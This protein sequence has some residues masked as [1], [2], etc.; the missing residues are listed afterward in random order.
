MGG[1]ISKTQK[2]NTT[3][4]IG[5]TL[6]VILAAVCL[7]GVPFVPDAYAAEKEQITLTIK[8]ILT[9]DHVSAMSDQTFLY[10]LTKKT[11]D[12]PMPSGRGLIDYYFTVSGT[13]EEQVGPITFNAAG[14][15]TYELSCVVREETGYLYDRHVYTIEVFVTNESTASVIVYNSDGTKA[16]DLRYEHGFVLFPSDPAI[17]VD[18][19]VVKTV[20][21]NPAASSTFTFR[22][23]AGDLSNPMPEGSINGVKTVQ[24]TGS[25]SAE[26]G[27]W[28]YTVEGTYFYTVSEVVSGD[29]NYTYDSS[30]YTITDTVKA[31]DSRL[32]VSRVVTNSSNRQVL[33]MMFINTYRGGGV[34]TPTPTPQPTPE[35]ETDLDLDLD[36]ESEPPDEEPNDPPMPPDHGPPPAKPGEVT[37]PGENGTYRVIGRNNAPLGEWRYEN[38]E[39]IYTEYPMADFNPDEDPDKDPVKGADKGP[40]TG[41]ESRNV[42]NIVLFCAAV[43]T[44]L[45]SA[46]YLVNGK[47]RGK[48]KV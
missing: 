26:F 2:K 25:G 10:R 23:N 17:M 13:T 42:L 35:P 33:S 7:T 39:W 30:V 38:G 20:A 12:A 43:F 21:G 47:N 36:L 19:P 8:Q 27:T 44:M 14:A 29:S 9:G 46:A 22:L 32:V 6:A 41:D 34:P 31:E 18:P 24:I 28:A 37:V 4:R 48:V 11:T 1:I 40:K 15:Y 5:K 45:L 3:K 16:R